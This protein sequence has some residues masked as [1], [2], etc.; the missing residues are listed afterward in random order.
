MAN[1]NIFSSLFRRDRATATNAEGGVA[2]ERTPEQ[3]LAQ[4]VATGCLNSTFYADAEAQLATILDLA[5]KVPPTLVAKL[6]IYARQ[7]HMKDTPALLMAVLSTRDRALFAEVFPRVIDSAKMIRTFV[8]IMR[9]GAVGRRSLGTL[10][11]RLVQQW[12]MTRT[13]EQL[14]RASVGNDPSLRDLLRIVHPRP[15][16]V[17]RS[18]LYAYLSGK[19]FDPSLLPPIVRQY[20]A[21]KTGDS[22]EVPDV[23]FEMLTSLPLGPSD[24][25]EIARNVPWQMTRMNL[26]TFQRH[27]VFEDESLVQMI[28]TRL[29]DR[30]LIRTSRVL[31]YQLMAAFA[32]ATDAPAPIRLALQQALEIALE[33]VPELSGNVH[34]L[35]DVSGSMMSPV[36]GYRKGATTSVMCVNAAAL[37]GAAVLRRNPR[38]IVM[39]FN[40]EVLPL[41]LNPLDTIATNTAKIAALVQGGTACSAPLQL[42]NAERKSAD[43]VIMVSDNQSW[44]DM[45]D[46]NGNTQTMKQWRR[47]KARCPKARLVCVDLQPSATV[48]CKEQQDVLNIGGFSD[49][50]FTLI[51]SFARGEM[52]PDHWLSVINAVEI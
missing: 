17:K 19:P 11:K 7:A 47:L 30:D 46:P 1:R 52:K 15:D 10:P 18:A 43:L 6:A 25:K 38:A 21:F 33:N 20:E 39:P 49:Q 26:N 48:Q 13:D 40:T 41:E 14:F 9:S 12:I 35:I 29:A 8:Q 27:G 28:A 22:L 16:S 36:T 45:A 32:N 5:T 37:I 42:M 31:P 2:Y 50:V 23:P 34:V 51:A 3:K 24:W 4:F 44:A